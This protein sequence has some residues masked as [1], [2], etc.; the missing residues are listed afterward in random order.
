VAVLVR[1]I[2]QPGQV[3][4][5]VARHDRHGS[6]LLAAKAGAT[7]VS[8]FVGR[9]DDAGQDG[10]EVVRETRAVFDGHGFTTQILAASLRH[11]RHVAE[12]ALG[13][14]DVATVPAEVLRKLLR[15][16]LTDRGLEQFLTDWR[17]LRP[18]P[19][20]PV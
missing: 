9:L 10:M 18:Q 11:P 14:A 15:H 20:A 1:E 2:Q 3:R 8:A 13:G 17:T 19:Q 4:R 12:A 5:A 6:H 7:Y 16:P